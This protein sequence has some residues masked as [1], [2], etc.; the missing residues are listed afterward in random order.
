MVFVQI[1]VHHI[2]TMPSR[3]S[4]TGGYPRQNQPKTIM[5]LQQSDANVGEKYKMPWARGCERLS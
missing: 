3:K 4:N 1:A 2:N 5:V